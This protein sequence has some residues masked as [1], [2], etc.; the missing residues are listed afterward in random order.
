MTDP[1]EDLVE[2]AKKCVNML[3][4][5]RPFVV[6]TVDRENAVEHRCMLS[7]IDDALREWDRASAAID[8]M[9]RK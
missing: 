2:A 8:D 3:I 7:A 5:C 4:F 9:E 1:H 6:A